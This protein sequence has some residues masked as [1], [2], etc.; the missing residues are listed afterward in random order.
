MLEYDL[1]Q[2]K[3]RARQ[4]ERKVIELET[5]QD[6][7]MNKENGEELHSRG[8]QKEREIDFDFCLRN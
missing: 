1:V 2:I 6:Q 8:N 4:R 7:N 3:N 5:L